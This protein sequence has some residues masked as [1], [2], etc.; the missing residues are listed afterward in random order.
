Y[1]LAAGWGQEP[2]FQSADVVRAPG[3]MGL[4]QLLTP[5]ERLERTAIVLGCDP[6]LGILSAHLAATTAEARLRWLSAASQTALDAVARGEAH[7]AGTHL[8]DPDGAEYNVSHARRAL[9]PAGGL[10]VEFARWELGLA[11]AAGNPLAIRSVADLGR[12]HVR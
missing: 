1:P 8:P 5:L 3:L 6:S 7:V 10:V 12:G 2:G 11:V 4:D 9:G